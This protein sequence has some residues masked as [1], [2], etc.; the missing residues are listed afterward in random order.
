MNAVSLL[1]EGVDVVLGPGYDGGYWLIGVRGQHPGLFE[2]I[3][4]STPGVLE[5]TL[6][7]CLAATSRSR[8]GCSTRGATST[9]STTWS[10]SPIESRHCPAAGLRR[11]SLSWG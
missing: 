3:P 1:G 11:H 7:R 6:A 10:P 2:N 5:A 4:W 8:P 9:R